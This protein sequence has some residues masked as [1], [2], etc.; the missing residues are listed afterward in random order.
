V[1]HALM[2]ACAV[3][4]AVVLYCAFLAVSWA[5]VTRS[6]R[7][8]ASVARL[9]WPELATG[10]RRDRPWAVAVVLLCAPAI[11]ERAAGFVDIMQ[12]RVD[13]SGLLAASAGWPEDQRLL[14]RTAHELALDPPGLA[15]PVTV[16]ELVSSLDDD[17]VERVL[18]AMDIRRGRV[19]PVQALTDY[20]S[21]RVNRTS[22]DSSR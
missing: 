20:G 6:V 10:L 21:P 5:L 19:R 16:H 2:L 11:R 9:V 12:Q 14:V 3:V 1:W 7:G 15:T 17:E 13:W 18:V 8:P 22:S 4:G